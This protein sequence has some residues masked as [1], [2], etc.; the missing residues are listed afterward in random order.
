[1]AKTRLRVLLMFEVE[2]SEAPEEELLK[3]M[4]TEEAWYTEGH[5]LETLR[6]N[7]HEVH[8]G[9]I[10][11]HP[12]EVIDLIEKHQPDL[13]WNCVETFHGNRYYESNVAAIACGHG[14]G[15][16]PPAAGANQAATPEPEIHAN[17]GHSPG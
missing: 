16:F 8:L 13:V 4:E 6:E 5:V 9:P 17:G 3:Y 2:G 12:R 14:R 15:K 11:K 1:M 10:Y 7:G